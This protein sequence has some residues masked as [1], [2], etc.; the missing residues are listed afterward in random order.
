MKQSL[1]EKFKHD[2]A[3]QLLRIAVTKN[4]KPTH[5]DRY[6][7][8]VESIRDN[9]SNRVERPPHHSQQQKRNNAK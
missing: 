6:S 7:M 8:R 5:T 4:G 3:L 2:L 9:G 1:V